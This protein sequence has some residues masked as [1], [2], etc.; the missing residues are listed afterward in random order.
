[1]SESRIESGS[2]ADRTPASRFRVGLIKAVIAV[3][4]R[5][6]YDQTFRLGK[7]KILNINWSEPDLGRRRPFRSTGADQKCL[8]VRAKRLADHRPEVIE[9]IVGHTAEREAEEHQ[10]YLARVAKRKDRPPTTERAD[11]QL[12][13]IAHHVAAK[14]KS[15]VSYGRATVLYFA[16]M[17]RLVSTASNRS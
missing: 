13:L 12:R 9:M 8:A 2:T 15:L 7:N 1:M 16:A 14:S 4:G 10:L 5:P 3:F 6:T 11:N 17:T